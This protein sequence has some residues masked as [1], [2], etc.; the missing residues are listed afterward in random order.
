MKKKQMLCICILLLISPLALFAQT[1]FDLDI[2]FSYDQSSEDD[3]S[4]TLGISLMPDIAFGNFGIGLEGLIRFD[5]AGDDGFSFIEEDWIPQF[6]EDASVVDKIQETASLY[7]PLIRYIR[8]GFKGD[9]LYGRIGELDDVTIGTG[10][11]VTGYTNTALQPDTRIM[12][13]ELDIDGDLFGFP[14]VG[15]ESFM[16]DL[17]RYNLFSARLYTRPF[18]FTSLPII[19]SIQFGG[20]YAADIDPDAYETF[21]MD[22]VPEEISMYGL[23]MM[24]PL[25][26]I[27]LFDLTLYGDLAFQ[28]AV[29]ETTAKAYRAGM[30]GSMAGFI[31]YKFDITAPEGSYVPD[32]FSASYDE[33]RSVSYTSPIEEGNLYAHANAGF[34]LFNS[35]L[36]LDLHIKGEVV[37]NETISIAEPSMEAYFRLGEGLLPFFY[38]DAVYV[39]NNITGDSLQTFIDDITTPLVDSEISADVTV[40]YS[41]IKTTFGYTISYDTDGNRTSSEFNIAG[42]LEL[43][44]F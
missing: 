35:N 24:L 3:S 26:D 34:D 38:F 2:G 16:S 40:V 18:S 33:D 28:D 32:Y 36:A 4:N 15:F 12:G 21:G 31:R 22:T 25:L 10:M 9:P 30:R 6:E 5:I 27:G 19:S 11:F 7:L 1:D 41:F 44:F 37:T 14:F 13:A 23:D 29:E 17:T 39:R 20:S 42:L 43:P 8:Y